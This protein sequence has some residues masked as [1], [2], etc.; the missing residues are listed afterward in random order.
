[1][2]H[3]ETQN[4]HYGLS[5]G[6]SAEGWNPSEATSETVVVVC[7]PM[8]VYVRQIS[9]FAYHYQTTTWRI[10]TPYA[11]YYYTVSGIQCFHA[12]T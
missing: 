12:K 6:C 1:M 4:H 2:T 8:V 10:G 7:M 3:Q 9:N 5:L 11:G